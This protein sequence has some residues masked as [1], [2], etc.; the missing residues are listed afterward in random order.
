MV[1]VLDPVIVRSGGWLPAS[2][3]WSNNPG[4]TTACQFDTLVWEPCQLSNHIKNWIKLFW[5]FCDVSNVHWA[6][7]RQKHTVYVEVSHVLNCGICYIGIY[8]LKKIRQLSS[9]NRRFCK[10]CSS[11][12]MPDDA[13]DHSGHNIISSVSDSQLRTPTHLLQSLSNNKTNAVS[14]VYVSVVE[15]YQSNDGEIII[16]SKIDDNSKKHLQSRNI[17]RGDRHF[18]SWIWLGIGIMFRLPSKSSWLV[19]G[20]CPTL[21]RMASDF[22]R[23]CNCWSIGVDTQP[24][25]QTDSGETTAFFSKGNNGDIKII[26]KQK[27]KIS[28]NNSNSF[29]YCYIAVR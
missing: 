8:R 18:R 17:C 21:Q 1:S 2:S 29:Y 3:L 27:S 24:N 7:S 10:T 14:D 9:S 19:L 15:Q 11:L 16:I 28:S 5:G 20:P 13:D 23:N 26:M 25:A 6:L 4:H 22:V 12:L